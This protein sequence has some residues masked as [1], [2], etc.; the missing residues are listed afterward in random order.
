MHR[1]KNA[2][3]LPTVSIA[4]RVFLYLLC[5]SFLVSLLVTGIYA[6]SSFRR[7]SDVLK[8][9][10]QR[11]VETIAAQ[12]GQMEKTMAS[13]NALLF[14]SDSIYRYLCDDQIEMPS[15]EWFDIYLPAKEILGLWGRSQTSTILGI[16]LYRTPDT[17]IRYGSFYATFDP[18]QLDEEQMSRLLCIDN[19]LFY[20][21][22]IEIG[23]QEKAFIVTQLYDTALDLLCEG[24][25]VEDSLIEICRQDGT[26]IRTYQSGAAPRPSPE[27]EGRN[28]LQAQAGLDS[29]NVRFFLPLASLST[30]LA[31]ASRWMLPALLLSLAVS[32]LL[33]LSLSLSLSKG[34]R[35]IQANIAKVECGAYQQVEPMEGRDELA[36]TSQSLCHMAG[37]IER[38]NLENSRKSEYEHQL[39]MQ[40]LRAQVSPHFLYNA[41]CSVQQLCLMQGMNHIS[42]MC[43]S[44]I[45]LLRATL[46]NEGTLVSLSQE[47]NYVRYYYDICQYQF[48]GEIEIRER[49]DDGLSDCRVVHMMLQPI[50]ENAIIHGL[51]GS[52]KNGVVL[53]EGKRQG[54][55]LKLEIVDNGCG[56][57]QEQID[58][59][60]RQN[61]NSDHRRFS[62]IG[63]RNVHERIR[64]SF[65]E[66]Y[67]LCVTSRKGC[68]TRVTIRLPYLPKEGRS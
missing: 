65:G 5:A 46:A 21:S 53:I 49:I 1:R 38:L 48:T 56:M 12:I 2:L 60:M 7:F 19:H 18:Y 11:T 39:E 61:R 26:L 66:A 52:E 43:T 67:G 24:L 25:L 10:G 23:A 64:L 22:S 54:D 6:S 63:V 45:Q 40:V 14:S 55:D 68:Y 47:L 36:R 8:E 50:V 15:K 9:N 33:S 27:S 31:E 30:Y 32:L 16:A 34:F 37:E 57:D 41:L 59:M 58:S 44:L 4:K 17:Q 13:L 20:I 35:N 42:R 28:M 62:G 3:R 51:I 29:W